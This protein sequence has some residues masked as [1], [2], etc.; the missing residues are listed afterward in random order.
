MVRARMAR[1]LHLASEIIE[2]FS[3]SER[4]DKAGRVLLISFVKLPSN[5]TEFM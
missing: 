2:A 3:L 5:R 1:I 4:N